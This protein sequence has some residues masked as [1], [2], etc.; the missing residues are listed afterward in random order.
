MLYANVYETLDGRACFVGGF[1]DK[2]ET[3]EYDSEIQRKALGVRTLFRLRIRV[4]R[5]RP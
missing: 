2:R 5:A 3:L 1:R 4:K